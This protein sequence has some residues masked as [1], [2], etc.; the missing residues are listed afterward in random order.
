MSS[1]RAGHAASKIIH[2]LRQNWRWSKAHRWAHLIEE[3]DLDP[4]VRARR[5]VRKTWWRMVHRAERILPAPLFLV[6]VQRSGTN[7]LAHSLDEL[8]EFQV[9]NEGNTKA[10]DHFRI[11]A[12][13]TIEKL[14]GQSRAR[15]V[16]FKPLCDSHRTPELLEHFGTRA[17][18][19]W[20]Y[21]NVDGRVRS[22][23]AK[24]GDT[25][26]RVL[27]AFAAGE[28]QRPWNAWQIAGLSADNTAFIR[29][30]DLKDIT[31]ESGAALFWYV[32][33]ALYFE[34]GL[35]Q[36]T[37]TIL[38]NYDEFL[39]EPERV[40]IGTCRFL[41]IPYRKAMIA[42]ID[43]RRPTQRPPLP[44]DPRI[45]ER[46]SALKERLDATCSAQLAQLIGERTVARPAS[47][48]PAAV[49]VHP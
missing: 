26:L 12:L 1:N 24:F 36:R 31:A 46:C 45:R 34:L 10:F 8:P 30:F 9:Y 37:D 35:N 2:K 38:V 3:H 20:A 15:F 39:A 18:A 4:L 11:R 49:A 41:E 25:N 16:L 23:V 22:A 19:I 14:V 28:Q 13:S 42:T 43:Q 6:G 27:R 29:S 21:R 5:A 47:R 44:I 7:L 32:R 40:A 33:N 17:R 48:R